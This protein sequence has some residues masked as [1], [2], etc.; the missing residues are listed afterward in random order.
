MIK[1]KCPKCGTEIELDKSSY[2]ELLNDIA[3]EEVDKRVSEQTKALKEKYDAQLALEQNKAKQDN[4]TKLLE[5][6]NEIKILEEKLKNSDSKTELEV[7]KANSASK[8]KLNQKDQEILK[9]KNDFASLQK[10]AL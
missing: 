4:L 6:Q 2:N 7:N 5:L 1:I 3:S 10:D 8:E 9:L